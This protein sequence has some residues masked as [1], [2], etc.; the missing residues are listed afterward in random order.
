MS[1]VPT[2]R[3]GGIAGTWMIA[4]ALAAALAL[5]ACDRSRDGNAAHTDPVASASATPAAEQVARGLY[6][7]QAAD[8]AACHTAPGGAPFAGGV[9]LE[10]PF[11]TFYGTNITPD[12]QHGI[13]GWSADTFYRALH[14]GVAPRG[15]LYPAMPYPSYRAITRDDS[16]AI[17]AYLTTLKPAAVP[18]REPE[19]AF[20]FNMRFAVRY[21][22]ML[23]VRDTL[24]DASRGESADWRRGRYLATALGHCGECHTPRGRFGNPDRSRPLQGD[25][26]GRIAAPDITPQ[27]LAA[28]GWTGAD[29]RS[30][31]S[32][33]IAPQGSAFSEMHPVVRL[34]TSHLNPD[35]VRALSVYLLG[36]DA[37]AP[38]VLP[39]PTTLPAAAGTTSAD[40]AQLDAGRDL[41]RAVCAACHGASGE[42][43]PHVAVP[44]RGNATVRQANPH[45]LIVTTLDGIGALEFPHGERMQAMPGFAR[46]LSDA[47]VAQLTNW[48]R[49]T[50]GGQPGDV[51]AQAVAKF[52]LPGEGAR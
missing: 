6:L 16:D 3:R 21:W 24:P 5:S 43:K 40:T 41:Y 52:R 28:R 1:A 13:G 27:A 51:T 36:D 35:D 37:P 25:S 49:T 14:D 31:F 34:S 26:P 33:G 30:F 9:R 42:G 12:P 45:N 39:A 44:L 50:W 32:D 7:A 11:G 15:Q 4:A 20:P 8:C 17:Y 23:F 47:D 2:F 22:N 38:V 48:L 46:L 18:N 29:L 19:L 10:S